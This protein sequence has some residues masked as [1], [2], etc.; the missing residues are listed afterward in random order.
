MHSAGKG[1]VKWPNPLSYLHPK[2][3]LRFPPSMSAPDDL[4]N[5]AFQEVIDDPTVKKA[6]RLIFCSGKVYYDLIDQS[7]REDIAIVR[8]EQLYPLHIEKIQEILKNHSQV[9]ECFWVQE[10]PQN[11]GAYSYIAPHLQNLLSEKLPVKVCR[12]R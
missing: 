11:Q 1:Q 9:E 6:K 4:S 12:K 7:K 10:E 8:I 5:V 2:Q 3:L